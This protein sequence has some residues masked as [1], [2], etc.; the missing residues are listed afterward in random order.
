VSDETTV[1]REL[2]RA[3]DSR[4]LPAE[5]DLRLPPG[6][7]ADDPIPEDTTFN[8]PGLDELVRHT[9]YL[10]SGVGIVNTLERAGIGD[11][12]VIRWE[13]GAA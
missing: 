9:C 6:W 3:L 11:L 10:A 8:P 4:P 5:W 13:A 1:R 7:Q 2:I 12:G